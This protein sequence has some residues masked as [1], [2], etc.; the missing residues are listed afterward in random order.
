MTEG[1]PEYQLLGVQE[2]GWGPVEEEGDH[3][4]EAD[5]GSGGGMGTQGPH[6]R[7]WGYA[8]TC[9]V[10]AETRRQP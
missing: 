4:G 9:H 7:S 8:I 3:N 10:T 5:P 6:M 2:A 1:P